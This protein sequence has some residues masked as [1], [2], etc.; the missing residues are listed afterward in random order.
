MILCRTVL[1]TRNRR[2]GE[3][4]KWRCT[5]EYCRAKYQATPYPGI[6]LQPCTRRIPGIRIRVCVSSIVRK[7]AEWIAAGVQALGERNARENEEATKTDGILKG[8]TEGTPKTRQAH[9]PWQN[10]LRSLEQSRRQ[11]PDGCGVSK[12]CER[13]KSPLPL[14]KRYVGTPRGQLRPFG[15]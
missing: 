13:W 14:V 9:L 4:Q 5:K 1:K 3:H 11:R 6:A 8:H 10:H 15:G 7:C 12:R 2:F